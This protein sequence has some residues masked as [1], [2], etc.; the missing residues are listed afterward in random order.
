VQ[1]AQRAQ[2]SPCSGWTL[3]ERSDPAHVQAACG[4]ARSQLSLRP[5]GQAL[6]FV[7]RL[8]PQCAGSQTGGRSSYWRASTVIATYSAH[9]PNGEAAALGTHLIV[10][11]AVGACFAFGLYALLQPSRS[12]N[13]GLTAY[14]PPPGTV[15]T[16]GKPF[17]ANGVGEPTAPA[18]SI[19]P[20]PTTTG[21]SVPE[22]DVK[23]TVTAPFQPRTSK[24]PNRE[25]R[26]ESPK[27][28]GAVCIPAYDS[29]GAQT[30]PCG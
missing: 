12:F 9:R 28:R 15:V 30:R 10:Y 24:R 25:V 8:A 11:C 6:A 3:S 4:E 21:R 1:A 22:P 7:L 20:E 17:L 14:N 16:Y 26:I 29:S 13:P 18:A 2:L 23:P 19:E 27:R 5:L